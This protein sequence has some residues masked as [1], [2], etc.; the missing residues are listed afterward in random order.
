MPDLPLIDRLKIAAELVVP[1]VKQMEEELGP[2]QAQAIL[3]RGVSKQFRAMA[4]DAVESAQGS[5]GQALISLNSGVRQ[6]VDIVT[7]VRPTP[8]GFDM[9]VTACV[10]ARFFQELGEPEL[11][12]LLVC[13]ADFDMVEE[14]NDVELDRSQTIM[15]GADH[16][17]FQY[18]FLTQ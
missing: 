13:S 1:I 11:G 4:R 12:F 18:R 2:Q 6:G 9:D 16:C 8:E 5:G 14:M 7:D 17:D 3:R 10:Y 15:Q